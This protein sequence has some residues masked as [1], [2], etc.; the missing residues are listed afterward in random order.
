MW[1]RISLIVVGQAE[2]AMT[3]CFR[4]SSM[5]LAISIS[6]SRVSS[7]TE[8]ISRMYMRTG[9]VVRPKSESTV[10]SAASASSSTSSSLDATGAFSLISRVSA[11]GAWS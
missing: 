6:P 9:S 8:P 10:V 3:M 5:R 1:A 11:S 4:P 7:S 2:M